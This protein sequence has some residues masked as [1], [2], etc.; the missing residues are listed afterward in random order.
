MAYKKSLAARVKRVEAKVARSK[1]EVKSYTTQVGDIS[2]VPISTCEYV[3]LNGI[4]QGTDNGERLGNKIRV[5]KI[6]CRGT[7][8]PRLG[9][10]LLKSKLSTP[11]AAADF[12]GEYGSVLLGNLLGN[13]YVELVSVALKGLSYLDN[14][15]VRFSRSFKGG[16]P[17]SFEDGTTGS[18]SHNNLYVCLVNKGVSAV[19]GLLTV[20]V[21]YTDC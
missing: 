17:V 1:P 15:V 5:L 13:V 8:S 7:A 9:V 21:W 10:F 14:G 16:L 4:V 20:R 11:P 3:D 18:C 19:H 12:T 2:T 6:E